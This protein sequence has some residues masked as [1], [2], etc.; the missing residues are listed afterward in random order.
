MALSNHSMV[1]KPLPRHSNV[2]PSPTSK[3]VYVELGRDKQYSI[4]V[5]RVVKSKRGSKE[6]SVIFLDQD[7]HL[8]GKMV[9]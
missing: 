8:C 4:L 3:K 1:Y 2:L 5:L 9:N 7:V 6:R